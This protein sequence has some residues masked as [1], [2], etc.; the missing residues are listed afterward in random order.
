MVPYEFRIETFRV[1]LPDP[2]LSRITY[3]QPEARRNCPIS[4]VKSS[5]KLQ[6]KLHGKHTV[7]IVEQPWVAFQ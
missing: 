3:A 4:S 6:H 1:F 2:S 5:H 7:S